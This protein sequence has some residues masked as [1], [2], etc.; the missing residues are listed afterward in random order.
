M[1]DNGGPDDGRNDTE[2]GHARHLADALADL[3]AARDRR[4][5]AEAVVE[6]GVDY[7][8]GND[9]IEAD[10]WTARNWVTYWNNHREDL[11]PATLVTRTVST[12][13]WIEADA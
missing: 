5:R 4:V 7:H 9:P 2:L 11:T 12:T 8:D 13:A 10:E 6:W 1:G 3:L